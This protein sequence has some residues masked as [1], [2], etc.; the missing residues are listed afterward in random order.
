MKVFLK[1]FFEIGGNIMCDGFGVT[2]IPNKALEK[3]Q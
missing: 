1:L 3:K 2:L